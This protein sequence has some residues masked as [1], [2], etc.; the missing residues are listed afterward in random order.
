VSDRDET[1]A[2]LLPCYNEQGTIGKVVD[3][4]RRVLPQAEIYVYDNNS[5]DRTADIAAER[6][7][8]VR[9]EPHQGKG[10]V[11]RSMFIDI[12]ADYYLMADGDDT[13]P[14]E[15]APDLLAP[16]RTGRANMV[17]GDRLSNGTYA[18]ENKRRLHGMGNILVR[19]LVNGLYGSSINDIMTGYRAFD[20]F[21]VKTMPVLSTGFEIETE[22]SIHALENR[23]ALREVAVPYRDRPEGSHSKLSTLSDG[24][25]VLWA[26]VKMTKAYRP[27]LFFSVWA[28]LFALAGL[29]IGIAPVLEYFSS[30]YITRVPSAVLATGLMLLAALLLTCGLI[31]STI[32]QKAKQSYLLELMKMRSPARR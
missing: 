3:D 2:V 14:A 24:R 9:H 28:G 16:L 1:V 15:C 30:G 6:G 20:R 31:L 7:A 29:L 5:T 10:N 19:H 25:K 27:L 13:Y 12:D 21:F 18:H 32:V 26:I 23:F 8:I 17:I 4:F 22:L 11:V